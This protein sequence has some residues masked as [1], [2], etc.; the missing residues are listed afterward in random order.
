MAVYSYKG[1]NPAISGKAKVFPSATVCGDVKIGDNSSVWF[2]SVVRG[3]MAKIT[4]GRN[5]NI[6]DNA[7]VHTSIDHP[8]MIGNNVTI[9]HGAIIHGCTIGDNV[10]VGMGAVILD[11]AVIE[12][13]AMVAAMALVPQGKTVP[14]GMLALGVPMIVKRSLTAEEIETNYENSLEYMK[15]AVEYD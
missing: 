7:I 2:G 8:T 6:Q 11:G 14:E 15:M 3:D 10:L 5:T 4:I 9:G 13:N 12:K 1:I